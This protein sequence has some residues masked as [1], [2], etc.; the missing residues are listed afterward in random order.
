MSVSQ[1]A[2][3]ALCIRCGRVRA[4]TSPDEYTTGRAR[5]VER[6]GFCVCRPDV[7]RPEPSAADADADRTAEHPVVPA[8]PSPAG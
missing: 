3:P 4:A 6:R 7:P 5:L 2:E 8:D 1:T